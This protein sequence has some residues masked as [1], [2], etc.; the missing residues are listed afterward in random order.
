MNLSDQYRTTSANDKYKLLFLW[1][2]CNII[3]PEIV[4]LS[5]VVTI[6]NFWVG[7]PTAM[8]VLQLSNLLYYKLSKK[9]FYTTIAMNVVS[10]IAF[11]SYTVFFAVFTIPITVKTLHHMYLQSYAAN[12]LLVQPFI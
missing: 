11:G 10:L 9:L 4:Y 3:F 2:L 7:T 12:I 1:C 8:I 5:D 6:D